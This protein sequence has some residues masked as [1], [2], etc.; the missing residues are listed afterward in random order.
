MAAGPFEVQAYC[1]PIRMISISGAKVA[2]K[3]KKTSS[4]SCPLN[5]REASEIWVGALMPPISSR[6]RGRLQK[7]LIPKCGGFPNFCN[8]PQSQGYSLYGGFQSHGGSPNASS[9]I[10]DQGRTSSMVLVVG[11]IRKAGSQ[12]G[13]LHPK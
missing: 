2:L 1:P 7:S 12:G 13:G 5:G 10:D 3:A 11:H 8:L 9:I 4:V 6:G